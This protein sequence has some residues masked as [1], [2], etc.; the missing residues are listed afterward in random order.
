MTKEQI[1]AEQ[2]RDLGIYDKAFEPEIHTLAILEREHLDRVIVFCNTKNTTDRIT[3]LLRMRG[4]AAQCIHG[5]E[6]MEGH[7]RGRQSP[8]R[9]RQALHRDPAAAARHPCAP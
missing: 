9:C 7:G 4:I 2:M 1:Y 3:G 5:D 6:G 8:Q